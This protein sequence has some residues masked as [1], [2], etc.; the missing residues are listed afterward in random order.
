MLYLFVK[1]LCAIFFK[2]RTL[3]ITYLVVLANTK[4]TTKIMIF[5]NVYHNFQFT[6]WKKYSITKKQIAELSESWLVKE[7]GDA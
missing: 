2:I 4:I 6:Q 1:D 7:T 5:I 3:M